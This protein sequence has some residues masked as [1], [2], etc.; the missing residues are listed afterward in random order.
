[1]EKER[2]IGIERRNEERKSEELIDKGNC[3]N[4]NKTKINDIYQ[5]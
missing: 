3:Y 2:E 4:E 5:Q 1:M